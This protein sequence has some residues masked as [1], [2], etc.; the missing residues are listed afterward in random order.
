MLFQL[1]SMEP[2]GGG[3]KCDVI[4]GV[5][6]MWQSVTMGEGGVKTAKKGVT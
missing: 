5:S 1:E 6:R 3:A 4:I 2:K